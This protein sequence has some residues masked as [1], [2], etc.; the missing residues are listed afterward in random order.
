MEFS[1]E[2]VYDNPDDSQLRRLSDVELSGFAGQEL[3]E[4]PVDVATDDTPAT[5][6]SISIQTA[7][8]SRSSI[9]T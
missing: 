8:T 7:T 6:T 1:N 3:P 9:W 5:L 4:L 2:Q